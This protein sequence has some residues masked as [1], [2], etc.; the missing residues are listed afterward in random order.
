MQYEK[1]NVYIQIAT[2]IAL[3]LG[4]GLVIY[5][6]RQTRDLASSNFQSETLLSRIN[7]AHAVGGEY[8]A[9]AI[10]N[11]CRSDADL[12]AKDIVVLGAYF[13]QL[14]VQAGRLHHL[15]ASR[16]FGIPVEVLLPFYYKKITDIPLGWDWLQNQFKS[17][18]PTD[19]RYEFIE[20]V[21][22]EPKSEKCKI[23]LM[24]YANDA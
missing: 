16:E 7:S 5:E 15:E 20:S 22:A 11:A 18:P 1:L 6:L 13:E 19:R 23:P 17:V 10:A 4:I 24:E 21:L 9:D 3:L 2:A 12:S 14:Y 8:I